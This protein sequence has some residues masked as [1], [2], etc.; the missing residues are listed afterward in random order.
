VPLFAR[1]PPTRA[2][3]VAAADQARGRGRVR[4]AAALYQ[5]ALRTEPGDPIVN[6]RL[7]P[8]LA[9]IGDADGGALA[10]RRAISAHLAAGF[11]DRAAG[12]LAS[13]IVALPLEPSFRLEAAHLNVRRGRQPDALAGLV[14]GART[15][16][17]AR[18]REA[19]VALLRR[20]LDLE[21]LHLESV[22]ALAPL[23]A[24]TGARAEALDLVRRLEAVTRGPRLA[25]V[26][27]AAFR[28]RP[29]PR[30]LWRWARARA[31]GERAR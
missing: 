31:A 22:L 29:T 16:A 2:E 20:A 7:A 10:F 1:R 30:A 3:L 15:L 5:E 23:L 26:R 21:P 8:L 12:V 14:D 25:R 28:L 6:A 19:A 17:T 4:K 18:R 11:L 24:A 13:A 9:R 27:W